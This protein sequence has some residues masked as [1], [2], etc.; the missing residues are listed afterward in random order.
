MDFGETEAPS[1][2]SRRDV[3]VRESGMVG[4]ADEDRCC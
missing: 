3:L 4:L 2:G 1:G